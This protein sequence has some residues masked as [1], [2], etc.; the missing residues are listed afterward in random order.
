M[1]FGNWRAG[2]TRQ[3][4]IKTHRQRRTRRN[5]QPRVEGLE[6]RNLLDGSCVVP[7]E[8]LI[9]WWTGDDT[10]N[11]LR[12]LNNGVMQG[13]VGFT[14]GKVGQGFN[15]TGAGWVN[16]AD[17]SS[18]DLTDE[19]TLEFWFK[20]SS[21]GAFSGLVAKRTDNG[22]KES[23]YGVNVGPS[24]P[25]N[26][27]LYYNDP[28][29][30]GQGDD[31]GDFEAIRAPGAYPTPDVFHHYAGTYRQVNSTQI[32]LTIYIDGVQVR[33]ATL[34]GNLQNT[35]NNVPLTIGASNSD[36]HERFNG[37]I[38]EVSLYDRAL[39]A[40]EI[41]AIF[42][43]GS[44]GKCKHPIAVD[45]AAA[46]NEDTPVGIN[47]LA[48]DIS[49]T[50]AALSV[51]SFTNAQHG[52]L[53]LNPDGTFSYTPDANYNG[54]D[55]FTYKLTSDGD[56]ATVSIAIAAVNDD[57]VLA[58]IGAKSFDE[59]GTLSFQATASDV[60]GDTLVFALDSGPAGASIT[61]GG[62][63]T[64]SHPNGPASFQATVRVSD[65]QG[66]SDTETFDITVNNVPPVL[67]A[68]GNKSVDEGSLLSFQ[69]TATD[70]GADTLVFSLDSAPAGASITANGLFSFTPADGPASF[71]VT[72]RVSDGDDSDTETFTITVNNVAPTVDAGSDARIRPGALFTRGGS[73]TDPGADT[74]SGLVNYGEGAGDEV[75][76]LNPDKSFSLEHRYTR[77]GDYTVTVKVTDDDA[78][79]GTDTFVVRVVPPG[80]VEEV[81]INDGSRQRSMITS[82]TITFD[83]VVTLTDGGV[84]LRHKKHSFVDLCLNTSTVN[85]KTVVDVTF[86]GNNIV[87]GSLA[88]GRYKLVI[89]GNRI[90]NEFGDPIDADGDGDPG[91]KHVT[92]FF[93]LF[94]DSTG[95]GRVGKKDA[96]A[97]DAA[98]GTSAGQSGFL[99]FFDYD[100]NGVIDKTDRKEFN[101]RRHRD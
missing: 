101:R 13:S 16:V 40:A 99:W 91:G 47:V 20:Y 42:N 93:R 56:A 7:P 18:L 63:F 75:L 44:D 36:G 79:A 48:N 26:F 87:G 50:G 35:L 31:G 6:E 17:N 85:G 38:D 2:R 11:D 30:S 9:S 24:A 45:D 52:G 32:E 58:A 74:W 54:P 62:L 100:A 5:Y 84:Q 83:S 41:Q 8:G 14:P 81:E 39:S 98:F 1:W 95:N 90:F 4:S 86:T 22:A 88:D 67:A 37:V 19:L 28:T 92:N 82:I 96:K 59:G 21:V 49:P 10:F 29:V 69:A 77:P 34:L 94:G 70:P 60:D 55:S 51:F 53:V 76:A 97:F 78:G 65:G 89:N 61:Q 57:P 72:V 23:N 80:Q 12:G 25:F 43:A 15:F 3:Q 71:P 46:T 66:G 68:I 64:F 33:Q 27:G 73:F